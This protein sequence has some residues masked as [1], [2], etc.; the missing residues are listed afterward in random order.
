ME[1]IRRPED[2]QKA[3]EHVA[4]EFTG[5]PGRLL[6]TRRWLKGEKCKGFTKG[7]PRSKGARTACEVNL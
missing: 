2:E 5:K 1:T 7:A 4:A 6:A 3:A